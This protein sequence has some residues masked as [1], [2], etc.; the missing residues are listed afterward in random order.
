MQ[1]NN[2]NINSEYLLELSDLEE[3]GNQR[4]SND[5]TTQNNPVNN[6]SQEQVSIYSKNTTRPAFDIR[7]CPVYEKEQ[8]RERIIQPRKY[9]FEWQP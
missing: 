6:Y 3:Q 7:Q 5:F 2:S 9:M 1:N 8:I 4:L